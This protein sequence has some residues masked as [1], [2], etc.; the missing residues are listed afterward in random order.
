MIV[1]RNRGPREDLVAIREAR[2]AGLTDAAGAVVEGETDADVEKTDEE[3]ETADK[4]EAA[5]PTGDESV[6]EESRVEEAADRKS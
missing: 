3:S 5:A 2:E 4:A 1:A 6:S